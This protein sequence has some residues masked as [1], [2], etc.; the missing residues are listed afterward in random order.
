MYATTAE[1]SLAHRLHNRLFGGLYRRNLLY[2]TCW[3][4]PALDV[5]ALQLTA[6]SRVLVIASAGCNALDYAL[7]GP[8]A[9]HAVDANPRQIALLDLKLAGIRALDWDDFFLLFGHGRHPGWKDLYR[10]RLRPLLP[11]ASQRIWDR[12]GRWFGHRAG[13]RSFY[14]H[15]L[16]GMVARSVVT[17]LKLRRGLW[18]WME[19]LFAASSIER[20]REIYDA[21]VGPE[22]IGKSLGWALNRQVTMSMLGVPWPQR[23][24]IRQDHPDDG[25][26]GFVRACLEAVFRE[27]P[28]RSNYFWSLYMNGR[29]RED[30]C[31]RYLTRN[32][33]AALK[34]GLAERVHTHVDTVTGFLRREEAPELDRFVLLDHMDWMSHSFPAELAEEWQAISDRAAP[35]TRI[36]WRSG[37]REQDFLHGVRLDGETPLRERLRLHPE[38]S[39]TLHRRD[40]VHTYASFHIADLLPA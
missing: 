15:G 7:E 37:A 6:A 11:E 21:H 28:I 13:T 36:L 17:T 5:E 12:K 19:A 20:Q 31:P 32:G 39:E 35:G 40:R 23:E 1:H 25:V 29:Y 34:A 24:A 18:S 30:C 38:W 14:Y 2:N 4:D 27:L 8:Q 26:A 9:V 10:Q 16:S 3:E 33:F 22:L